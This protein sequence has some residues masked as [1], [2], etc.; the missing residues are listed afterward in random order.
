VSRWGGEGRSK[1]RQTKSEN[2]ARGK[3]RHHILN[4]G[5]DV[6]RQKGEMKV[7]ARREVNKCWE[8]NRGQ[9]AKTLRDETLEGKNRKK[10]KLCRERAN[11][12][13][14][15]GKRDLEKEP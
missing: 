9:G 13:Q 11:R 12:V 7:T 3:R 5:D 4:R 1:E 8:K 14:T 10:K 15:A 2:V 6:S